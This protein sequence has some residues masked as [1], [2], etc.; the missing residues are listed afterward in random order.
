MIRSVCKYCKTCK[1]EQ[2]QLPVGLVPAQSSTKLRG[3]FQFCNSWQQLRLSHELTQIFDTCE[4][5]KAIKHTTRHIW[6]KSQKIK[7]KIWFADQITG[8][9]PKTHSLLKLSMDFPRRRL[10]PEPPILNK[11]L[12]FLSKK[13]SKRCRDLRSVSASLTLTGIMP[14]VWQSFSKCLSSETTPLFRESCRW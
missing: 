5:L 6:L 4:H 8:W 14:W 11:N 12:G 13:P 7:N 10:L 1:P 9:A 2:N 3:L